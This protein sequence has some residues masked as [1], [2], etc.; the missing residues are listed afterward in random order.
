MKTQ[1][2]LKQQIVEK[3]KNID[4]MKQQIV[5]KND[6]KVDLK[7]VQE[8]T[9]N[10]MKN[11]RELYASVKEKLADEQVEVESELYTLQERYENSLEGE[12]K[13]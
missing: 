4:M 7:Q 11:V 12:E 1:V 3:E 9:N 13:K 6:T 10:L 8:T 5:A 2:N